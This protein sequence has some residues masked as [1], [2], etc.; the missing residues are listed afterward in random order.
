MMTL[1]SPSFGHG[2]LIPRNHTADGIN[3][4]PPLAWSN[5][6]AA[7]R[8]LALLVEDPDAPDPAAPMRIFA[9]WVLYNIPPTSDNL[10]MAA[11]KDQLPPGTKVGRNDFGQQGYGGPAPPIGRHRYFF[12]LFALDTVLPTT[13][14]TLDRAGLMR[15]IQGHVLEEAEL[16]GMYERE[17]AAPERRPSPPQL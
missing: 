13:T 17:R 12:R 3:R 7:T 8:S 5:L 11:G 14:G 9:H 15:A 4:S 2:D 10:E 1:S 16:M 6:P